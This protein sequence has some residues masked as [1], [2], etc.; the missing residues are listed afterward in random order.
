VVTGCALP[1]AISADQL[2]ATLGRRFGLGGAQRLD[3]FPNLVNYNAG[4]RDLGFM[5]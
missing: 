2:G 1:R 4:Q 3:G 5:T